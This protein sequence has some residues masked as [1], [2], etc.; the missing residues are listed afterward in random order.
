MKLLL[1]YGMLFQIN[2]KS[3]EIRP[4]LLMQSVFPEENRE[5]LSKYSHRKV[6][7]KIIK[8]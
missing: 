1:T 2:M 7:L 5:I 3:N 8:I 4:P 6:R